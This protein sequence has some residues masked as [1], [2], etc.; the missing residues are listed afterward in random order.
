MRRLPSVRVLQ[1]AVACGVLLATSPPV[2]AQG[3]SAPRLAAVRALS[4]IALDGVLDEPDWER[5]PVASGFT[6]REP[7][8]GQPSSEVTQ[9]RVLYDDR[10]L[11]VGVFAG[12][13]NVRDLIVNELRRDFDGAST[14]WVAVIV[15]PFHDR[16]NGYQ[17]GVNPA[18]AAWDSQKFNDGRER[19]LS[20]DGVWSVRT[21]ITPEGWYA[22]Y[23]IPFRTLQVPDDDPQT[24]GINFQRHLQGQL[25]ESFWA[26]V[27]R[28]YQLDRLSLAGTLDGLV[29]V[30][31]GANL[32][33]KPYALVRNRAG[34]E[35][36]SAADV[37]LD[38]K[39]GVTSSLTAD[40]TVHTDFSQVEADVQQV[41]ATRFSLL[42]P[43]KREFFLENSGV[44]Q[45]G[46]GNGRAALVS[47]APGTSAGGR[48]NSV[49]NDLALFFSRRIGLSET[50][51]QIPLLGGAR[52][53]GR[54]AGTTVGALHVRQ[55]D[56]GGESASNSTV[57][58]ARRHLFSASDVGAMLV[59]RRWNG[60][61]ANRV[62]GVDLNVRPVPDL[63]L[64][65]YGATVLEHRPSQ[66]ATPDG[67]D[68]AGRAGATWNDGRWVADVSYG[69]VGARFT[70]D[71]G[72]VPR[73]GVSRLQA[74]A[75]RQFRP[76]RLAR[77]L[78]EIYPAAGLTRLGRERGGFDSQYVEY[79]LKATFENGA[80][81][82]VGENPNLEQLDTPFVVNRR[83]NLSVAPGR[84]AFSDRFVSL[85]S[86][87]STRV[88]VDALASQGAYYDGDRKVLQVAVGGRLN[89]HLS[90]AL[91]ISRDDVRL[92][93]GA[94]VITRTTARL[95]Y[96]FSTRLFL[97]ALVQHN[98]DTR[99]WDS[100][101]RLNFIH[102]PL[103]DVFIVVTDRRAG[104]APTTRD[105]SIA[106]K[107]TRLFA[108]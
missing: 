99:Q 8:A 3:G 45:F 34:A 88:T 48:D 44:F 24:W 49:Q 74:L 92:P 17:F 97:N 7:R 78:R 37:G 66:V 25:E 56:G 70:D 18:G 79:R 103:S 27:P 5:A 42:F 11:Y 91:S 61:G 62:A 76:A 40:L 107:V 53:S 100:N 81:L 43:E 9:V 14:D 63:L 33:V 87:R 69:V 21:R 51:E 83:Q 89:T 86:S 73:A 72:F 77:W 57:L 55:Q 31:P 30:K 101:V 64:Y 104:L 36:G 80:S 67:S 41:G 32:R 52:L 38:V 90:G 95:N 58:R 65:G 105:R 6:Q 22:E 28:P 93:S 2:Q 35:H 82:E 108:F 23:A 1:T 106:V 13:R 60:G 20:W 68:A 71:A 15:D 54:V 59:E 39:Y 26:P 50:G 98:S 84:Y 75:G 12:H 47:T 94:T 46:P 85:V 96:G 29:G 102:R 19:N 16:R 10:A 4:A